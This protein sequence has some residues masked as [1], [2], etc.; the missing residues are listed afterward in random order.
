[1]KAPRI[2]PTASMRRVIGL[3][4]TRVTPRKFS[5]PITRSS[6]ITLTVSHLSIAIVRARMTHPKRNREKGRVLRA[7]N[8]S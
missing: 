8:P 4:G 6:T 1:M 7:T 5:R 3:M 2:P